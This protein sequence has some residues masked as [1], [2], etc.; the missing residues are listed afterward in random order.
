M[1]KRISILLLSLLTSFT[2]FARDYSGHRY[3]GDADIGLPN[4]NEVG[5]GLVIALIAIPIGYLIIN[6]SES[7]NG[8]DNMF[9]GCLGLLFIGGGIISL[10]P[11]LAWL[12]AIANVLISI[13]FVL[14]IIVVVIGFFM[15]K[16]K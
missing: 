8:E 1:I 6:M 7:N 16:S 13:G 12:C 10:L 9:V 14:F 5:I 3:Y 15:A 2:A 11:L 4:G